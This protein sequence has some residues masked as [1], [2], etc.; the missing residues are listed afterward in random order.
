MKKLFVFILSILSLTSA[1]SADLSKFQNRELSGF[2]SIHVTDSYEVIFTQSDNYKVFIDS[3]DSEVLQ[4]TLTYLEGTTL[5]VK[6]K[7]HSIA[8]LSDKIRLYVEAPDIDTILVE[9]TG[10]F[11]SDAKLTSARL[12]IIVRG[13]GRITVNNVDATIIEI[14]KSGT[15]LLK[16]QGLIDCDTL[17][18]NINGTGTMSINDV[19]ATIANLN[20]AGVSTCRVSGFIETKKLVAFMEGA[21]SFFFDGPLRVSETI[22]FDL[23]GA[24]SIIAENLNAD[25]LYTT[26]YGVGKIKVGGTVNYFNRDLVGIGV[27]DTKIL[28]IKNQ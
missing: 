16:T 20:I 13:T 15:G 18:A 3:A 6:Y 2:T 5:C 19:R 22:R 24:G 26:L 9:G 10:S 23:N 8:R 4:R 25:R 1:F 11:R 17:I 28:N 14:T 21:G 12:N 7:A 27:I